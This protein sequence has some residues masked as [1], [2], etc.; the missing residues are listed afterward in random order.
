MKLAEIVAR[1]DGISTPIGGV[2]WTP[3]QSDVEVA[4]A[5]LLYLEDRRVLYMHDALEEPEHCVESVLEIRRFLTDRLTAGGIADELV[6]DL[7]ALRAAGRKFLDSQPV[8]HRHA[9]WGMSDPWFSQALGVMRGV[10]GVHVARIAA[11]YG[12]EVPDPLAVILPEA[13]AS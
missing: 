3:P 8:H 2:S 6:A 9:G 4:R 5:V 7:R 1:L 11:R 10:F 12:L 13:D